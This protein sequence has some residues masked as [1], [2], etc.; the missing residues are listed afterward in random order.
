MLVLSRRIGE[1]I[2]IGDDIEV[3]IVGYDRGK[4]RIGITAPREVRVVRTELLDEEDDD[5]DQTG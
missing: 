4:V 3:V 1:K 5:A 2:K